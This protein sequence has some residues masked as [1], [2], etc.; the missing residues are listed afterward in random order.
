ME[1]ASPSW[2]HV[3]MSMEVLCL[4]EIVLCL[5]VVLPWLDAAWL[6]AYMSLLYV[7]VYVY[8]LL[9]ELPQVQMRC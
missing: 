3:W 8:K 1:G 4:M 2:A 6:V 7:R 9:T 5:G